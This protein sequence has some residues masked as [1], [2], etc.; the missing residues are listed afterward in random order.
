M[1]LKEESFRM[2]STTSSQSVD[3]ASHHPKKHPKRNPKAYHEEEGPKKVKIQEDRNIV[4][5]QNSR[6]KNI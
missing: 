3:S 5:I 6:F 2:L 4:E 1:M